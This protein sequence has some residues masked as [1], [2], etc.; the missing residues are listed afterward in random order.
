MNEI[1]ALI[2]L[3]SITIFLLFLFELAARKNIISNS[4]SRKLL[5]ITTGLI[6][7]YVPF[8]IQS[9]YLVISI[10]IAFS[11]SNFILIKK[12]LLKQINSDHSENLGIFYYPLS[13]LICVL[14]YWNVNKYLLSF[15]FLIF[16]IGDAAAA[17][18]GT[19][20]KLKY[21]TKITKEPKTFN[22]VLAFIVSTLILIGLLKYSL[23]EKFNFIDYD[24][25]SFI[26][27][28]VIFSLIGG[29]TEAVS[30]KGTDNL[31]LPIIISTAGMIFFVVGIDIN[32]FLL[33]FV[34][35][36][37]ISIF[38]FKMKFLNLGGS[39]VTFLLA[40]FIYGL[41][42]W[43]WTIPILIFFI[44]SSLLSKMA[45]KINGK[46]VNQIFEKGSQ[47]DYKQVLANGGVPLFVCVL[48]TLIPNAIDWYLVYLLSIAIST[49]DT[50]STEF[51]TLF[52]KNVY[53]ITSFKKVEPGISGGISFI[54]TI[55][56]VIGSLIIATSGILFVKIN[57]NKIL[58]IVVFA[59]FGNLFDSLLGATAQVIYKCSSCGKLT[60]KKVH[61]ELPTNYYKGVSFIDNDM[62]NF[63]SVLFI[64]FV[65]FIFLII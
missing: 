20:S 6:V 18:V 63:A 19:S 33:A 12:R 57:L 41:G 60:E 38:S 49:A 7:V 61:C 26:F 17:I 48:N 35:A 45:D 42:G 37:L 36:T 10:G 59:L 46:S 23:W 13:F 50:W 2:L 51:G 56:G 34:L 52:A 53:L 5:H 62:V 27:I 55:G 1:K 32:E 31:T 39:A 11:I 65:Y 43:K 44:L 16:S 22:G 8:V 14:L 21:F 4:I 58:L 40:L 24:L 15:S 9:F 3:A 29:I 25:S 64:S 47:R 28:A 30:T 54:G